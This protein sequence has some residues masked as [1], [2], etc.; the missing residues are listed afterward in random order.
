MIMSPGS[1]KLALTVHIGVSVG[2]LGAV[3]AYLALDISVATNQDAQALRS[4][5]LAMAAI[6][7][8]V[9]VPLAVAALLT[10]LV[11]SLGTRW[12]LVRHYWVV[13]SLVST[14][15]AVAVLLI[16]VQTID[17][18]ARVAADPATSDADL[19]GL[20]STLAHSV[21]GTMV[22]LIILTLNMVKPRGM[23]RYGWRKERRQRAQQA[24]TAHTLKGS[25]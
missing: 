19:R 25:T 2:W 6:A 15:I 12:G 23:T 7:G 13:I 10:G 11:M 3:A 14:I 18:L 8:N 4:G 16:E 24:E 9:I 1:R 21:G 22:L 20:G 17:R 5:Y